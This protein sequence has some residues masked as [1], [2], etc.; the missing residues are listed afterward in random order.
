MSKKD[1]LFLYARYKY[2]TEG[3]CQAPKPSGLFQFEAKSKW[4]SWKALGATITR[5]QCKNE[6]VAKLDE[7]LPR[8]REGFNSEATETKGGDKGTFGVRMSVMAAPVQSEQAAVSGFDFCKEG[9]LSELKRFVEEAVGG[10]ERV[11][12]VDE[13]GM[14]MLMWACDRGHLALV[15]YLVEVGGADVNRQDGEGQTCLHY[16]VACE[17]LSIVRYLLSRK[18]IVRDLRDNEG[19]MP[20]DLTQNK[21]IVQALS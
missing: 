17:H 5:D 7:C 8:W 18:G 3:V 10:R 6:Y 11:N 20:V 21:E 12:E 9:N 14:T 1:L 2:A 16:A 15:D 19:M 4:E 13:D